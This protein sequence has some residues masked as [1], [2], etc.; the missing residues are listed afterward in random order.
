MDATVTSVQAISSIK[1]SDSET[2]VPTT[3]SIEV[4]FSEDIDEASLKVPGSFTLT[5]ESSVTPVVAPPSY[6][7]APTRQN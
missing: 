2:D 3:D 6:D 5:K 1:P 7:P 4:I